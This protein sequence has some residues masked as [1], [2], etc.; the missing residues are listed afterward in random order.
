M[1]YNRSA[2]MA[3]RAIFACFLVC[4][5]AGT[6]RNIVGAWSINGGP[7]KATMTFQSDGNFKT[8]ASGRGRSS[9]VTGQYAVEGDTIT[10]KTMPQRTAKLEWR[11]PDEFIMTGDDGRAMT[12]DRVK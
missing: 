8:E 9:T 12:L 4:G 6:S 3:L 1:N 2:T 7:S 10:I 11:T 5:C